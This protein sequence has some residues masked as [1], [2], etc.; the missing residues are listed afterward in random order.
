[1]IAFAIIFPSYTI[2]CLMFLYLI[3]PILT[4]IYK[5]IF[6]GQI[7]TPQPENPIPEIPKQQKIN[8]Q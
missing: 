3:L 1:V 6:P 2:P 5:K 8:D 7:P 4:F